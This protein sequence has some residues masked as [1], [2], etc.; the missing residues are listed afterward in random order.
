VGNREWVLGSRMWDEEGEFARELT[1]I[2]AK[3]ELRRDTGSASL[4]Q[5]PA[6]FCIKIELV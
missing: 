2:C 6:L 3:R 4:L 5:Y 1:R